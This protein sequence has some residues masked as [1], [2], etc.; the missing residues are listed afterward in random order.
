MTPGYRLQS[1]PCLMQDTMCGVHTNMYTDLRSLI[2]QC[3][4]ASAWTTGQCPM[5]TRNMALLSKDVVR[6]AVQWREA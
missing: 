2:I 6:Q 3:A 1:H 4:P 5:D